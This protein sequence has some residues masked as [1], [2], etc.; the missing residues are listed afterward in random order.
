MEQSLKRLNLA[1]A[2]GTKVNTGYPHGS[3]RYLE[4]ILGIPLQWDCL[5]YA[6]K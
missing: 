2:G 5:P 1:K 3:I 6:P 4:I